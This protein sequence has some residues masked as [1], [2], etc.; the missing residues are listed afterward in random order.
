VLSL[1]TKNDFVSSALFEKNVNRELFAA[2]QFGA[3][4]LGTQVIKSQ[5]FLA[6]CWQKTQVEILS[7]LL[8]LYYYRQGGILGLNPP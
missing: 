1:T 3:L 8:Q 6:Q 4:L 2:R 5:A 7:G